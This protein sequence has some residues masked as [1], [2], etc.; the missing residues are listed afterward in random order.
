MK[1]LKDV[2][3]LLENSRVPEDILTNTEVVKLKYSEDHTVIYAFLK[4]NRIVD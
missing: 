3:M 4:F 1:S 2:F